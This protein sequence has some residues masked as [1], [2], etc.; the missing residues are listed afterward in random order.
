MNLTGKTK[1]DQEQDQHPTQATAFQTVAAF[2]PKNQIPP[3][4]FF[5]AI[6]T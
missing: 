4:L 2:R 6:F 1:I 5:Y 3:L